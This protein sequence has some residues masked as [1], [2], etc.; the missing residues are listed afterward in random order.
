MGSAAP[1][2]LFVVFLAGILFDSG[3]ES[4]VILLPD[5]DGK[6]GAVEV[7]SAGGRM[8]L[9]E[10]GQ[11]TKVSGS[12]AP[13]APQVLDLATIEKEF[14]PVL[15]VEPPQPAKFL[16]YF[17]QGSTRLTAVSEELLP[18]VYREIE[19]RNSA[20]IGIYGHSDRTGSDEYNL[21][22]STRRAMAV[23]KLLADEGIDLKNLDVNS[24]GEGNPL[25]PTSD[26]VAEPR[27]RRVEVIVR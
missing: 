17:E 22:L 2:V 12:S 9:D 20:A 14:S 6:V 4:Q 18:Q 27:N 23:R 5:A 1:L 7:V 21:E 25:I 8:L 26:G 15:S 13:S 10:V 16:L 3:H 24:H 19:K 11:M